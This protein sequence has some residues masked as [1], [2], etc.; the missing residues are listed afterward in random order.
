MAASF[1]YDAF[2][3]RQQA[4]I[5]GKATGYLHDGPN[6][7]QELNGINPSANELN[8]LAVDDTFSRTDSGGASSLL[9]DAIGSTI[10]LAGPSGLVSTR[11][12][13]DP[14]GAPTR[15]GSDNT[16]PIGFTGR[17]GDT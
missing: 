3:R 11:Y 12:S 14:Y 17:E 9:T 10:A 5:D 6:V 1:G 13:Y 15:S 2:G 7:V 16:N 8:G 4:T